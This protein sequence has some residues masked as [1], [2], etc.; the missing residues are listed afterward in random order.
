MAARLRTPAVG[1]GAMAALFLAGGAL[2]VSFPGWLLVAVCAIS[3]ACGAYGSLRAGALGV[4]LLL[5]ALVLSGD[6][7]AP[8]VLATVGPWAAGYVVRSRQELIGALRDRT[9]ELEAEQDAFARLAVRR[10][11][12]RIAHE[13]HDI[14]AHHLAVMVIHAGAARMGSGGGERLDSIRSAGDQALAEMTRLVAML[15]ADDDGQPEQGR[16]ALLVDQARATGLD[17]RATPLPADVRLAPEVEEGAYR[18]VQEGLTNAMKHAPGSTVELRLAVRAGAVEIELSDSGAKGPS[19]LAKTGS[20]LGLGGMRERIEA[21]GGTLE[22]GPVVGG[23]WR[24]HAR[25]PTA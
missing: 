11:R 25:V 22:A 23:G 5:V 19:A 14:V 16:L 13:L 3:Y 10:E 8:F 24:L 2:D 18:F 21:L 15:G 20:G 1:A 9:R 4:A 7:A 6:S 12:A 17:L